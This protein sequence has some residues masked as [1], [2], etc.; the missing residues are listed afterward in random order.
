[1]TRRSRRR[2]LAGSAI[3]AAVLVVSAVFFRATILGFALT[4]GA[5]AA[6]YDVR[7]G[8][9]SIDAGRLAIGALDVRSPRGEPVLAARSIA[10]SYD[11]RHVFG[12]AHP[13]GLTAI[14]IDHPVL[15]Y[16]KHRDGSSNIPLPASSNSSQANGPLA[17]PQID[18]TLRDGSIGV[19]DDSRIFAHSRRI[20]VEGIDVA[21]NLDPRR[22]SKIALGLTLQDADGRFPVSGKG[23]LDPRRGIELTRIS[24]KK[25]GLSAL[26][27]YALNSASLHV[28]G[29]ELIGLDA[30]VYGMRNHAGEMERHIAVATNLDHFQPYLGGIAKP[31]R[32]GRG[33]LRLYDR[34]L[35]IPKVDGSIADI[36]VRISGGI[37]DLASPKLRLGIAGNGDLRKLVTLSDAAKKYAVSGPIAFELFVEGSATSP[38]TFVTFDSPHLAYGKIPVQKLGGQIALQGQATTILRTSATYDGMTAGAHGALVL[39]KHTD[40]SLVANVAANARRIPYAVDLLGG[41]PIAATVA[42]NGID[43]KLLTAGVF[44]GD[45]ATTHLAGTFGVDGTGVGE[46]GPVTIDGPADRAFYARVALDRPRG[47][48]GAGF[49]SLQD[50]TIATGGTEPSLPG[51]ALGSAPKVSGTLEGDLAAA[52]SGK[53]VLAGGSV[54]AFG[55]RA[56]GYPVDDL[57]ARGNVLAST[58]HP[59]DARISANLRYRGALAPIAQA[60]G[61]KL[62]VTGSVDIPLAI[63]ALGTHSAI[64]QIDGARFDGVSVAGVALHSLQGTVGIRGKTIDVY[65]VQAG[66]GDGSL[67]ARGSFGNG[68]TL[69]V[70]S[71]GIDLATLRAAGV[72]VK[73]GSVAAIASIAGSAAS[74]S[75][76]AGIAA[77]GI[78]LSAAQAEGITIDASTGLSYRNGTLGV[79]D[80]IVAAGPAIAQ[81]DGS[82]S[83]L[84][85]DPARARYDFSAQLRQA[86]IATLARIGHASQ[87]YPEGEINADV[88][89]AGTGRSPAISGNVAI[90]EGSVNGL[91]YRDVRVALNGNASNVRATGGTIT[92]GESTIGFGANVTPAAQ[93]F[94]LHAPKLDLADF[95]DYFDT[96]EL[97]GGTGSVDVAFTNAPD[98]LASSGRVRIADTRVKHFTLGPT[99]ADW[100]TTGRTLHADAQ[101]G[102]RSGQ[103]R[104]N[105]DVTFA[106]TA[107][108]R[109][110]LHRTGLALTTTARNVDLNVWLPAAGIQAPVLGL[111]NANATLRG[112]YPDITAG[113]HAELDRGLVQRVAIRTATIDA[114]A[115]R[116]RATITS[117]VLAIDNLR[118]DATGSVT[119]SPTGPFDITV[120]ANTP[121][122]AALDTTVTGKKIDAAGTVSTTVRLSGTAKK[123]AIAAT[124]DATNVRYQKYVLPRAH[125]EVAVVPGRVT[126]SNSEVDFQKGKL[127]VDGFAPLAPNFAGVVAD[128]PLALNLTPQAIDLAQFAAFSPKGTVIAGALDGRVGLVGTLA[129]PG[130]GGSLSLANGS[131]VGPQEKSKIT[132]FNA[133]V[134]FA[135]RTITLQNTSAKVGGGTIGATGSLSVPDLRNP[136]NSATIALDAVSDN[137]VFDIPNLF[138]GRIN[139][140]VSI[141]RAAFGDYKVGGQV[142]VTSARIATAGL[143]PS[144]GATPASNATPLPVDLALGVDVGND[145]RVQGG[146]VDIGAKGDLRVAGTLAAP[147]VDGTLT[148][149]GGTLSFYRTFNVQY[150]STVAFRPSDGVIPNIDATATTDIESPQTD[151]TLHVTGPATQLNVDLASDPAYSRE[152]ILGLLVGLNNFGAVAGVAG[153]QQT[154]AQQNPF[155]ALAEGQLGNL[156]TQN[157]LEPFSSQLGSAVGLS[158]LQVNV[159][160]GSAVGLGAQKQIAKNVNAVFAQSFGEPVRESIGLRATPKSSTAYQLT[161]YSQPDSNKLMTFQ[162]NSVLSSNESVTAAEPSTGTSGFSVSFQRKFH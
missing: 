118:A 28:A 33:S 70:S 91:S 80:A 111:V 9:L 160:P 157:V 85:G 98:R 138:K 104:A 119:L 87:L 134:A 161:F 97:L 151:I 88:H 132:D 150:P 147:T 93:T 130:L 81:L 43:G 124:T 153:G 108:L 73:A 60:A 74:P 34:G 152:Q 31:L 13:F 140:N 8:A 110:A 41:M 56:A 68:G 15:T 79:S 133:Q 154:G 16:I 46:I 5:R 17:I 23:T 143:L 158:N 114:R 77:G 48:G 53:N 66:I 146:P 89:V 102:D 141:A 32:D 38:V 4:Q 69:T 139:G 116:G 65:G 75:V 58:A 25:I 90:P 136:A 144:G 20:A 11:L 36:P 105:G 106:T 120:R 49:V 82:V 99:V 19:R 145:V 50:F 55:V 61:A 129:A 125:A 95:N 30:L 42:V 57:T 27:D 112:T 22:V 127:L 29:G 135:N 115:A 113:A 26:L 92:V 128:R 109:D 18:F 122:L 67:V 10:V 156:L 155:S 84:R 162:P 54:H 39:G 86:D 6:G 47:G 148:S 1:M 2:L 117:A 12:S 72:P 44:A 24:A 131:F 123:I 52:I 103:V 121:D 142:A 64:A 3:V 94:A 37:Y 137:A 83:G 76:V 107:P 96:G 14:A 71:S 51:I 59:A 126:V 63:A 159:A 62:R 101:L 7:Y 40:V 78:A 21:A 149:T 100:S 45:T 35:T